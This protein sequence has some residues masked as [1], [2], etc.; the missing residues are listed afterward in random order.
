MP[1][2]QA[3]RPM[4]SWY[5]ADINDPYVPYFSYWRGVKGTFEV[6]M[7]SR[8]LDPAR[9]AFAE[10]VE[11]FGS[12]LTNDHRKRETASQSADIDTVFRAVSDAQQRYKTSQKS[13]KAWKWLSRFSS[14]VQYYGNIMDVL[15][16][17]HPEYV[18]LAWG[19]MKFLFGVG[20]PKQNMTR[21]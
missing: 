15:V 12:K 21:C 8:S 20:A 3:I 7:N 17:H 6:L 13:S 4:A 5:T 11:V 16:Q 9:D 10:A 14:R 18:S 1:A 2:T 19:A